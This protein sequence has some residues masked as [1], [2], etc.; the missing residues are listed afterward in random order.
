VA[1]Q[2]IDGPVRIKLSGE[3]RERLAAD[4]GKF[5]AEEF[6]RVLSEFQAE[7]L[8]DF[9]VLK[10]GAPVYNQAIQDSRQYLQSKLDELDGEFYEPE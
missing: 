4:I 10:L 3:A 7:R 1:L 6:D 9:L 2:K 8:I 5:F